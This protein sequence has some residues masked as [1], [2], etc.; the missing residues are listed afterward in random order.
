MPQEFDATVIG[1]GVM[2]CATALQLAR[3]GMR[4][5]L[6]ERGGLCREASGRIAGT[7]TLMYTRAALIPYAM[8]G[9]EMWESAPQWL[10]G[11]AGFHARAGIEVALTDEDATVLAAEMKKRADAGAPIQIIDMK[12]A[13]DIEPALSGRPVLAAYCPLDGYADSNNAGRLFRRALIA[14]GVEIRERVAVDGVEEATGGYRIR[15]G[16]DTVTTRRIVLSGGAWIG[17]M[18]GWFGLE[19]P[20]RVN[21][22]TIT[23]RMKPIVNAII[24]V[25][26]EISIKQF[27]NGTVLLGGGKGE[28]WISDPDRGDIELNQ[29]LINGKM[30]ASVR[31]ACQ[32]IPAFSG[33]RVVRTWTGF[34]AFTPDNLPVV[35]PLPGHEGVFVIGCLRSGFTTGPFLGRLAADTILGA[36]PEKP[37]FVPA[38]DPGRLVAMADADMEIQAQ[39]A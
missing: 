22:G 37:A 15:A 4:V 24:R 19:F 1:G 12:R 28:H 33:G 18:A 21:Q 27:E 7:L 30:T 31:A 23:E 20:I 8:R 10:G 11:D 14:E 26:G 38:F 13:R 5:L 32:V 16:S 34:E 9:R 35:G 25:F 2:G 29:D 17:K 6:I 39:S 3:G 36:E